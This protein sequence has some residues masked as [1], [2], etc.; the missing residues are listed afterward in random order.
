[1]NIG[2]LKKALKEQ[3]DLAQLINELSVGETNMSRKNDPKTVESVTDPNYGSF[4]APPGTNPTDTFSKEEMLEKI[5]SDAAIA[6]YIEVMK[7]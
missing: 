4:G 3:V 1:A 2:Q 7:P 6:T 5:S